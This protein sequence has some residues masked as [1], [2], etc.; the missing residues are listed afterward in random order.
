MGTNGLAEFSRHEATDIYATPGN[1][2]PLSVQYMSGA[3]RP[4]SQ[5]TIILSFTPDVCRVL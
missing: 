1:T 5:G 2:V 3:R 4:K